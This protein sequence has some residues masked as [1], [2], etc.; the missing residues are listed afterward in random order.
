[1]SN[2]DNKVSKFFSKSTFHL[3]FACI[4]LRCLMLVVLNTLK[5]FEN[6]ILP[7]TALSGDQPL[8]VSDPFHSAQPKI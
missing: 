6:F 8:Q 1:M 2:D 5:L 7:Q 4:K 3:L